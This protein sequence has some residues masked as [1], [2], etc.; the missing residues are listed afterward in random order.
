M[1]R[2]EVVPIGAARPTEPV[3]GQG[4]Q[5]NGDQCLAV[6]ADVTCPSGQIADKDKGCIEKKPAT[7]LVPAGATVKSGSTVGVAPV[8]ADCSQEEECRTRCEAGDAKGCLGLGAVLR[9]GLKPGQPTPQG[10]K[11]AQAFQ[12]A[13]D[14][15]ES[16]ACVALG[17]LY[18][19]GLG[20]PKNPA[21]APAL[22]EK[23]CEAG[24]PVGCND[25]GHALADGAIARDLPRAAQFYGQAC[26]DRASLGCFGLGVLTR[27]GRGVARDPAKAKQLFQKACAGGVKVACKLAES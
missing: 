16:S 22:F 2:I 26:N 17:E 8:K 5:W 9:G 14:A 25:M 21:S 13:C 12:K 20:V 15:G 19:Q 3:C 18:Y 27:D 7:T 6:K 23:A 24:D 10:D 1:L 11:A 4:T